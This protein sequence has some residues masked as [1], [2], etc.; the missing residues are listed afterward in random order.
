MYAPA[1]DFL[2]VQWDYIPSHYNSV[3]C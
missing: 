1:A 2:H 3:Y